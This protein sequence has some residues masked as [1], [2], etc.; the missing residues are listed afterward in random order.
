MST[1]RA[2]SPD[3]G[4]ISFGA[5]AYFFWRVVR[6][7]LSRRAVT[8]A[9]EVARQVGILTT[10]SALIVLGFVFALGLVVGIQGSYGAQMVG[11]PSAAGAIT[12][13]ANLREIAPYAFGYM[14]SAKVGTGL[15]AEIGT[16]RITEEIDALEVMGIDSLVY[17][18]ST[19]LLASWILLPFVYATAI[20]VAFA[21][22]FISVVVQIG[23]V[24]AGGYLELFWKFQS[25]G[26]Y[27]FS[28]AKGMTMATFVVLVGCYFGYTVR[29][30]PVEVGR[31]TARCMLISLVG[32]HVIGIVGSQLFWGGSARLPIGG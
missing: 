19:R 20:L 23:Q 12:A 29:G 6:G 15:V 4:A 30:G 3:G 17:L 24:S 21:G 28:A 22:S 13:I 2:A 32:V 27:L 5:G 7:G 26:D 16:R 10:G 14:M 31:A 1:R 11:T 18:C 9:G 25:P 8:Y